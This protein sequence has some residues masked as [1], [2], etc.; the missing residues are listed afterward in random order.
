MF[1]SV[2]R[3]HPAPF[4]T[5]L[6]KTHGDVLVYSSNY[7]KIPLIPFPFH[8]LSLLITG[9]LNNYHNEVF[10]GAKWQCVE[11][12]RRYLIIN[13]DV[14]YESV[15]MAYEIFRLKSALRLKDKKSVPLVAHEN[16]SKVKPQVGSL[17]I[18]ASQGHFRG[19]GHVAVVVNVA[20][21]HVDIAEQNVEDSVWPEGKDYSRRLELKVDPSG[22]F[23]MSCTFPNTK[24][25]G[26]VT[27]DTSV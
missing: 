20:D 22:G 19:T 23:H 8:I 12:S 13:H 11:L 15:G 14:T 10:T 24:L 27:V 26:W 17:V 7:N 6:G 1:I 2:D 18:W 16:G 3:S 9:R 21:N 25:L 4:G 5:V